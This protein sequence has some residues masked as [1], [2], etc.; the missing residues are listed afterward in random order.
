MIPRLPMVAPRT[1]VLAFF[2]SGNL[3]SWLYPQTLSFTHPAFPPTASVPASLAV[4]LTG[5]QTAAA[6]GA[7]N[8]F[9]TLLRG[10]MCDIQMF[11]CV[12]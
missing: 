2:L 11:P 6:F 10:R 4:P 12:Y 5:S 1:G 3:L 8:L 9:P 7:T